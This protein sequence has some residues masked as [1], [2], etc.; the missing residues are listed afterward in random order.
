MNQFSRTLLVASLLLSL[1]ACSE[2]PADG[3]A[4][5]PPAATQTSAAP[6]PESALP[7]PARVVSS[8]TP[9]GDTAPAATHGNCALDA[10]NGA[11]AID[12]AVAAGSGT[13]FEGWAV[14]TATQ[15][16]GAVNLVLKGAQSFNVNG[17]TSLSRPDVASAVAPGAELAGFKIE[18]ARLDVPAGRYTISIDGADGS[19]RCDTSASLIVN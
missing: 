4:G 1:A 2:R 17:A 5:S 16:A 11:S 3:A 14:N 12:A 10:I 13:T 6:A 15:P 7:A 9:A 8:L 19:F 18:L